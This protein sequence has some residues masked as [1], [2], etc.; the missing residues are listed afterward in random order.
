[1]KVALQFC[2]ILGGVFLALCGI[3]QAFLQRSFFSC[4][5]LVL[6]FQ[7]LISFFQLAFR[8]LKLLVY[9][10]ETLAQ[11]SFTLRIVSLHREENG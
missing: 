5:C 1:M 3:V 8:S 2:R 11:I 9:F 7:R 4:T 10:F 6:F